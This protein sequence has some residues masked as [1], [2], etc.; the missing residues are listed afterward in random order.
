M[1]YAEYKNEKQIQIREKITEVYN[2]VIPPEVDNAY[3]GLIQNLKKYES[4][5]PDVSDQYEFNESVDFL[6]FRRSKQTAEN[7]QNSQNMLLLQSIATTIR[8]ASSAG[9]AEAMNIDFSSI[10]ELAQRGQKLQSGLKQHQQRSETLAKNVAEAEQKY[11]QENQRLNKK[12][13][14]LGDAIIGIQASQQQI[15]KLDIDG[16]KRI[17]GLEYTTRHEKMIEQ[18]E[19]LSPDKK[20]ILK[21]TVP[22]YL[23]MK[24]QAFKKAEE[25]APMFIEDY[26]KRREE[27]SQIFSQD[28]KDFWT[29]YTTLKSAII[30]NDDMEHECNN[31][32]NQITDGFDEKMSPDEERQAQYNL[33]AMTS[34]SSLLKSGRGTSQSEIF[35][36]E[37]R[38]AKDWHLI[39]K[40]AY[41]A[42][43]SNLNRLKRVDDSKV[44]KGPKR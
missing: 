22:A 18:I 29:N 12:T 14:N 35:L 33:I 19:G 44:S 42:I 32:I 30:D 41:S 34:L 10:I 5:T 17:D 8:N 4:A 27:P 38:M 20:E 26:S 43:T 36:D 24:I 21:Q 16:K 31:F 25:L 28:G 7:F 11:N 13:K 2:S 40:N 3:R 15:N 23:D 6:G 9:A 39:P 37:K 1:K